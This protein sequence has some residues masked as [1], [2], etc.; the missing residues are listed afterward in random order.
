MSFHIRVPAT[1][2][3]IGPGFDSIG[4]ALSLYN[5][6]E[7]SETE[8]GESFENVDPRFSNSDHLMIRALRYTEDACGLPHLGVHLRAVREDIPVSRGLGSSAAMISAGVCAAN[9]LH[10]LALPSIRLLN[11]VSEI[12]GH[13]DNVSPALFGGLTVSCKTEDGYYTKLLTPDRCFL[14][15]AA[16]PD[17]EVPTKEARRLLPEMVGREDAIHNLSRTGLL[18]GGLTDGDPDCLRRALSDRLHEPYRK[19][20]IPD[21]DKV[22]QFMKERGAIGTVISGAGPTLLSVFSNPDRETEEKIRRFKKDEEILNQECEAHWVIRF[23]PVDM[24]G[25]SV[26]NSEWE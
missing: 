21:F 23:L 5:E 7:I 10:G 20:L 15:A 16:I 8:G 14:F 1:S 26:V 24:D 18:L 25:T 19:K 11:L 3:N 22:S 12:E 2:A 13:P 17:F 9:A 4:I 6:Y